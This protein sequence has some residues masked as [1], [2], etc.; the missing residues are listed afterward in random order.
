V[1]RQNFISSFKGNFVDRIN[2]DDKEN[3]P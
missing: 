3:I 1:K 2:G